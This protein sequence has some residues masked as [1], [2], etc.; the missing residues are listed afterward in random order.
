V[1]RQAYGVSIEAEGADARAAWDELVGQDQSTALSR[2]PEWLDCICSSGRFT[3]ATLFFRGDDGRRH[4]LPRVRRA[5]AA[6]LAKL[7]ESPPVEWDLGA[8]GSGFLSEGGSAPPGETRALI[9]EVQR[10]AGLRTR[11]FVAGYD[12]KVWEAAAPSTIHA[13]AETAQVLDLSGGFSTVWSKRFTSKVRSNVRKAERRGVVVESD[14][15]GRLIPAFDL[16]YRSS[17]DRWAQERGLPLPLMRW[18]AMRRNAQSK[19]ALVAS[20]MGKR[21]TTWIASRQGEPIAGLIVLSKGPWAIFWRGAM[22][23]E[24]SRGTGANEFLHRCAIET[25][26]GEERKSYDFGLSQIDDLRRF[27]ATFGAVEVPVRTYYLER[28]P[29]AAAEAACRK[30]AKQTVRAVSGL[31]AN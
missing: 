5:G 13:T 2:T 8:D 11:V 26:A 9:Q 3:D 7:F 17:V 19:Y 12:A 6:S 31:V 14:N 20:R 15:G 22:D 18:L 10:H 4:I 27:K 24:R 16:L 28:L 1:V 25:A 21:C 29:T 30:A 23:K